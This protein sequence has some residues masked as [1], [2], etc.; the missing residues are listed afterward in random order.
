MEGVVD[1]EASREV[2][3]VQLNSLVSR[4]LKSTALEASGSARLLTRPGPSQ[5]LEALD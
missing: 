3:T 2:E 5:N 1:V 4:I